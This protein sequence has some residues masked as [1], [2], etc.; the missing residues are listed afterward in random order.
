DDIY[1]T[2]L[3]K[4]VTQTEKDINS[5]I[6]SVTN[7]NNKVD[8]ISVGGTN[9]IN[10]SGDMTGLSNVVSDKYRGNAVIGATVKAGSG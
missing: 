1:L 6:S 9:L 2:S 5:T 3:T 7:L 8:A 10:N 4:R